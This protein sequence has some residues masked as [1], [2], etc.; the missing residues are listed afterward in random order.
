MKKLLL[1]LIP[2][3]LLFC[4]CTKS[5]TEEV[6][7][8]PCFN[9]EVNINVGDT[10]YTAYLS[11]YADGYWRI[12]LLNPMAVK[13]LIFTVS[14]GE[15]EVGFS[16]LQFTFDTSRFPVGSVITSATERIDKLM[17]SPLDVITGDDNCLATGKLGEESFTLTLSK[18]HVPQKLEFTDIGMSVE[19]VSFDIIEVVEE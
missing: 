9:S 5:P 15:T 14:G 16:G 19:F 17:I 12:E 4:G 1:L 3:I 10:S 8:P 13:G 2:I 18:T 11:R 7:L 6:T